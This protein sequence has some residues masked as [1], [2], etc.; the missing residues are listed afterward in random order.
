MS[1]RQT[2]LAV[3]PREQAS[4]SISVRCVSGAPIS[5]RAAFL[6]RQAAVT[7]RRHPRAQLGAVAP[8]PHRGH[9]D[10]SSSGQRRPRSS[11]TLGGTRACMPDRLGRRSQVTGWAWPS[12]RH[13]AARRRANSPR[14]A[15]RDIRPRCTFR[16]DALT[17][18]I[19]PDGPSH[20]QRTPP[21]SEAL[22]NPAL[23]A[24]PREGCV[25]RSAI[26]IRVHPSI[27]PCPTL[28]SQLR[29]CCPAR[30]CSRPARR[31]RPSQRTVRLS[32]P[33]HSGRRRCRCRRAW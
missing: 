5:A 9:S 17:S 31:R 22:H 23:F 14:R 12:A 8:S 2:A 26:G 6:Q 16:V 25:S 10:Q 28:M 1:A 7:L 18:A 21:S 24:V 4:A 30:S 11:P 19:R 3:P 27:R 32:R 13:R 15:R 33:E 20:R 29:F